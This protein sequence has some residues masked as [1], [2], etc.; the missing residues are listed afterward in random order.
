MTFHKCEENY[1]C[2][3]DLP[4]PIF[5]DRFGNWCV[6]AADRWNE[7]RGIIYCPFCGEKL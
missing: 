5:L 7:V 3:D 1:D 2:Y 4:Y 6:E